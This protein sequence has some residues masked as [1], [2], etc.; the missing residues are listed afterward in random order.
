MGSKPI[1]VPVYILPTR[2]TTREHASRTAELR[3]LL[4][5]A[6]ADLAQELKGNVG[7]VELYQGMTRVVPYGAII[8]GLADAD[9]RV[10]CYRPQPGAQEWEADGRAMLVVTIGPQTDAD[11]EF[12]RK[13]WEIDRIIGGA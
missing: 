2:E 4:A 11:D 5:K 7:S 8:D 10:P 1:G 3:A 6:A 9:G 12:N 13:R